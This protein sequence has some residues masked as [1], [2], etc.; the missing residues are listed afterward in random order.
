[1]RSGRTEQDRLIVEYLL[2][3]LSP[4][5]QVEI[6]QRFMADDEFF[7]RIVVMEEEII[8]DYAQEE[9][10]P[11]ECILFE[12]NFLT[13]PERRR[14]VEIARNLID[15][16]S[17][18]GGREGPAAHPA[19]SRRW[20]SWIRSHM[21]LE[22]LRSSRPQFALMA[23]T[24]CV[25]LL[26][27]PWII[28]QH[29]RQRSMLEEAAT[30]AAALQ[31]QAKDLREQVAAQR[32]RG[33]ELSLKLHELESTMPSQ[34]PAI[35]PSDEPRP[36]IQTFTLAPI[37][38]GAPGERLSIPSGIRII[39]LQIDAASNDDYES[40]SA[41][42]L[43]PD[44]QMVWMQANIEAPSSS[45]IKAVSLIVPAEALPSGDYILTLSGRAHDGSHE[46][47]A[48]Y[49]LSIVREPTRQR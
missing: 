1:M 43:T 22:S 10:S 2:G 42:I 9:L 39:R 6:E 25:M 4:E 15:W 35:E 18:P 45:P 38:R 37:V 28:R 36:S 34:H 7:E 49:A 24:I 21:S 16:A 8:D 26:G 31:R 19:V 29:I 44:D 32:A 27:G 48:E 13:S 17:R 12:K 5:E 23:A 41:A 20:T 46:E 14:K 40:F 47:M 3:D 30:D 33:D 11:R